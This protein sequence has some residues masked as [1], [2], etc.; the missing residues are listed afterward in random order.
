[1]KQRI[2]GSTGISVSEFA[3]G[4]M[5]FG[6]RGNTDHDDSVRIIHTALDSGINFVDTADV[7]AAGESE[8]ILAKAMKGRRDD[9]VLATKF[10]LP[11]G[12]DPNHRGGSPRWIKHEVDA[13]LRRLGT[14]RIDLYQIHRP[15]HETRI[16]ETLAALSDLQ[17]DGKIIAFGSSTFPAEAIVDA[18]WAAERGGHHRFVTEQPLYSILTRSVEAHV[19]P[20]TEKYGMGVLSYSPLNAGWLSGRASSQGQHRS[21]SRPSMFDLTI[22]ANQ[23]KAVA[24]AA[25]SEV[26][27]EAG[28]ALPHLALGFVLAHPA[29]TS[30]LIGPRTMD[31]L[32]SLI[33]GADVALS[34]EILNRIDEI[35]APG[36]DVN[37]NDNYDAVPPSLGDA[38]LRRRD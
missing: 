14:D 9:I 19:S 15:D 27:D 1:M 7:Y 35:V 8:E 37:P 34:T 20:T 38:R 25:L 21:A 6:T 22:R 4:T 29:I 24:V 3:L 28:L 31:H 23:A 12:T 18:Q 32:T 26:A 5:M 11:M 16:D 10:G 36:T 2:L 30:V 17:R 13:S 33:A